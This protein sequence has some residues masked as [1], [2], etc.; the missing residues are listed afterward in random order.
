MAEFNKTMNIIESMI[1]CGKH[2]KDFKDWK[3]KKEE[4]RCMIG[5]ILDIVISEIDG[6]VEKENISKSQVKN[7]KKQVK[8][9]CRIEKSLYE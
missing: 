6:I 2:Y 3:E 4:A 7:F 9:L 5:N 1:W 8:K